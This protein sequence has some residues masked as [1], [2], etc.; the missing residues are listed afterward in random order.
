MLVINIEFILNANDMYHS[1]AIARAGCF[2]GVDKGVFAGVS[3][4]EGGRKW[5]GGNGIG[6]GN[7]DV[8]AC[9][10]TKRQGG[11]VL[12]GVIPGR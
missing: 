3:G 2:R 8:F 10:F 1:A 6:G 5:V 9:W 4:V 11:R 7:W 12:G